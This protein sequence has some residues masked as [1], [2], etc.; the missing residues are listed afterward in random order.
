MSQRLQKSRYKMPSNLFELPEVV[1]KSFSANGARPHVVL[2]LSDDA[3]HHSDLVAKQL[4]ASIG[5][6]IVRI[7]QYVTEYTI[8]E[9]LSSK[10]NAVVHLPFYA[11]RSKQLLSRLLRLIGASGQVLIIGA[12]HNDV[13]ELKP[14]VNSID[15]IISDSNATIGSVSNESLPYL[16]EKVASSNVEKNVALLQR[17]G[18][19]PVD[20]FSNII[21]GQLIIR[22]VDLT[23]QAAKTQDESVTT[24]QEQNPS[25]PIEEKMYNQL[26]VVLSQYKE[27]RT[28]TLKRSDHAGSRGIGLKHRLATHGR[29]NR[30]FVR[31]SHIGMFSL[32]NTLLVAAPH[33]VVRR[34][35][36]PSST[37]AYQLEKEDIRRYPYESTPA[38]LDILILDS[39]G[40]MAGHER[41]RYAKGLVRSIV[42]HSY[43]RRSYCSLIVARS[44]EANVIVPP[45]K[46]TTPILEALKR[47]PTGGRTP[48]YD[49]LEKAIDTANAFKKKEPSATIS[50]SILTDG[51]ENADGANIEK[52]RFAFKKASITRRVFDTSVA[53]SSVEFAKH[54]GASHHLIE[55]ASSW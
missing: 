47:I 28:S 10:V 34:V 53:S 15:V 36:A 13:D 54:I 49:S 6:H 42:S 2:T 35:N 7:P 32:F 26:E 19:T 37:L 30:A 38:H 52:L 21:L 27:K 31:N 9:Y 55:R 18:A 46:R 41:I 16:L 1:V 51:K 12:E 8:D 11:G 45:T 24:T 22:G 20:I 3:Y 50:I 14:V 17:L 29:P 40:S 44:Y 43:K 4:S 33:Q 48:L 25:S 23:G 39:S 5:I